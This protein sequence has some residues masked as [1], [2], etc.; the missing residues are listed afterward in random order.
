MGYNQMVKKASSDKQPDSTGKQVLAWI[1]TIIGVVLLARLA[2]ALFNLTFNFSETPIGGRVA[3]S[4]I[5]GF[6]ERLGSLSPRA[7]IIQ[8]G[9]IIAVLTFIVVSRKTKRKSGE[10]HGKKRQR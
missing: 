6:V 5:G 2:I 10:P 7:V 9:I 1:L 3:E 8:T 4:G